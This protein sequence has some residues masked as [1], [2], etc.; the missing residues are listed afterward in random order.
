M[1]PRGDVPPVAGVNSVVTLVSGDV[2]VKL[3]AATALGFDGMRA[4]FQETGFV[5]L[6]GVA[7]VPVGSTVDARKGELKVETAANGYPGTDRRARRQAIQIKIGIFRIQQARIKR[8]AKKAAAIGTDIALVSPPRAE[9][10][11]ASAASKGV[12]RSLS[13][14]AKGVYRSLGGAARRDG[15]RRDVH[16]HRPLRRHADR[17]RQGQGQRRRQGPAQAGHDQGR[18]R[19][20]R[21]AAPVRRQEGPP[22]RLATSDL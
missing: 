10:K 7:S 14:V 3:P 20:L 18:R 6:K 19:L 16:H 2:F 11:C 22:R 13:M 5:P 21:Q 17:G 1:L 9:A 8:R 15:A 12:V 4:P